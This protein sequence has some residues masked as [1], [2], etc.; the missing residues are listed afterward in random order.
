MSPIIQFTD[1]EIVKFR[2]KVKKDSRI[3]DWLLGQT[4]LVSS[5]QLKIPDT[6][7]ANW[8]L[9]YYCSECS[10]ELT[11]DYDK[12]VEHVCPLCEKVH[13]GEPFDSAWWRYI[14]E[15]NYTTAYYLGL[16]YVCTDDLKYA[17]KAKEILMEYAKRYPSYEV[18]GD[19]PYNGPG[20]ANAQTLC[21]AIF[22]RNFAYTYDLISDTLS[23]EEKQFIRKDLLLCGANFL[24]QH[25]QSQLH[26]H[27][28]II[29]AAIGVVGLIEDNQALLD[30]AIYN[31]YGLIYQLE[32]GMLA[33]GIWFECSLCYHFYALQ[34]FY[35]FERF[36]VHTKH[37]QIMHPNYR[38]MVTAALNFLQPND[39]FPMINDSIE[40]HTELNE[41]NLY[42]FSYKMFGDEEILKIMH[43]VYEQEERNN[44]ESFF[45]GVDQL[46]AAGPI[47]FEDYHDEA[48]SGTTIIRGEENQYLLFRH[49]KFGGEH[50][51]YDR[52]SVSYMYKNKKVIADL[53]TTGYGAFYH[54]EYFKNTGTHNTVMI[55]EE[56]Q[57]PSDGFVSFYE[58]TKDYT[59]VDAKVEW[60]PNYKMPDSFTIRQWSEEAYK[61]VKMNRRILKAEH[62][63]I[64]IFNVDSQ[65]DKNMDWIMHFGGRRMGENPH[66]IPLD[67]LSDKKPFKYLKNASSFDYT[68]MVKTSY[69][70]D[71]I[72]TDVYSYMDGCKMIYACGPGKPTNTDIPY[73]I[74]RAYGTE[75]VFVNVIASY[76]ESGIMVNDVEISIIGD[77]IIVNVA[78]NRGIKEHTFS[79]K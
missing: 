6:G 65:E 7:I 43:K 60:D 73:M 23:E 16:L 24:T 8:G 71:E 36:A 25:R 49:G 37:S 72:R 9:Y 39:K 20:K 5:N 34:N 69:Q 13:T 52:L 41:Y 58:K 44:I 53:G 76:D 31:D 29:N 78:S 57:A 70:L 10:V 62:Y 12:P 56:N 66:E 2:E 48:G 27:E 35:G 63:W 54:Y 55:N 30:F 4:H 50:D 26:N 17:D 75:Q 61:G 45:Y 46:P 74:Q 11:F 19:I 1:Q 38:K 14:N 15:L 77:E 28:V 47:E 42:E 40:Y 3:I 32:H 18:H 67:K 51:H 64:D 33:D 59:F 79:V 22:I 68:G 21:E